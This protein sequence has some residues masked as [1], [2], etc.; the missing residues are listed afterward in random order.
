VVFLGDKMKPI[1]DRNFKEKVIEITFSI[2]KGRVTTYGTIATLAGIP[3]AARIVGGILNSSSVRYNLPWQRVLNK[4]GYLSIKNGLIDSKKL[5]KEL[6]E[7]E[8]VE[9]SAE[10]VVDLNRFGWYGEEKGYE[11]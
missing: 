2:P 9:V 4:D 8:G 11:R 5:Q 7:Q 10:Y 1:D 6:L 3:R